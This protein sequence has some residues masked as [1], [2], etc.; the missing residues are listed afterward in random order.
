MCSNIIAPPPTPVTDA[1]KKAKADKK[2]IVVLQPADKQ[3]PLFA[4]LPQHSLV[5]S[6]NL[7]IGFSA[8]ILFDKMMF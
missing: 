5:S 6:V 4:H 3:V 7:N 2:K 8:G 1:K